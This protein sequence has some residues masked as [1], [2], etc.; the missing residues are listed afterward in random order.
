M[1]FKSIF[2]SLF[3]ML[4][5]PG[6]LLLAWMVCRTKCQHTGMERRWHY[7]GSCCIGSL[8]APAVEHGLQAGGD[9]ES[10]CRFLDGALKMILKYC[11]GLI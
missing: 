2:T 1:P 3:E 4:C 6:P 9:N 5:V 7:S 11:Y 8:Y 10:M